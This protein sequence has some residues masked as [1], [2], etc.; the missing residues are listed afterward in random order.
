MPDEAHHGATAGNEAC[1]QFDAD[2]AGYLEGEYRPDLIT[3]ARECAFCAVVLSDL[4]RL[5][6][7]S[8][9]LAREEPP[10]GVWAN[11]RAA[12]AAEG[13]LREPASAW[14]SWFPQAGLLPQLAPLGALACLV[15]LG[16]SLLEPP[17]A[18]ERGTRMARVTA[19]ERPIVASQVYPAEETDLARTVRD[20]ESSYR[21]RESFFEP[22]VKAT[23][24][25]GLESLNAS[26]SECLDSVRR[27]PA[28]TLAREYLL[29]AY[30][31]KAQV[32]A[33]A[34]EF[35]AR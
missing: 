19:R 23:Y 14:P 6:S 17:G 12:L 7:L 25:K 35:D 28:N 24:Q 29:T 4:E 5:R 26:I 30:A 15:I 11:I 20:M 21:A 10:P 18:L 8:R 1:G 9:E 33:V 3:H 13:I 2:L 31:R 32:L 27:E 34:L 16:A 22:A